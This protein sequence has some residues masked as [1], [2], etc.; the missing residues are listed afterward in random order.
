MPVVLD[1]K[2]MLV[3]PQTQAV[4]QVLSEE[5][6]WSRVTIYST[7]V[8]YRQSFGIYTQAQPYESRNATRQRLLSV[9]LNPG[10]VDARYGCLL[11]AE[12]GRADSRNRSE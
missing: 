12:P 6:T 11:Q 7:D 10:C 2:A 4:A 5:N 9:L 1:M 8:P 3:Q